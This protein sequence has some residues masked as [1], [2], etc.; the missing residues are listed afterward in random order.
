MLI[1]LVKGVLLDLIPYL[2]LI[3]NILI[4]LFVK[5]RIQLYLDLIHLILMKQYYVNLKKF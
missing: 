1:F 5:M 3:K 4:L 2:I